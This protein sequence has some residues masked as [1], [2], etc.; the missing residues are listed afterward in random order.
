M[1]I[2]WNSRSR[3]HERTLTPVERLEA[4][5]YDLG[6][7]IDKLEDFIDSDTFSRI[8]VDE[9]YLVKRQSLLMQDLEQTMAERIRVMERSRNND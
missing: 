9:Q 4:E 2:K 7:K 5:K 8:S 3:R 6:R 1:D